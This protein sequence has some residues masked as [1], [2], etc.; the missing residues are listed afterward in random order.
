VWLQENWQWL[1]LWC[2]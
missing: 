2:M 1:C